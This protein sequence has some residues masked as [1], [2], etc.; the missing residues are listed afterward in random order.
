MRADRLIS[1]LLLLQA[2]RRMTAASLA[3][4]LEVSQRT[5]LRDMEALDR[6]GVPVV[7]ERG[8]GGGWR[9]IDGYETRLTGLTPVEIRSLFLGRPPELLAEL[10]LK[11]AAD[12]AWFKLRAALPAGI[13]EQADFVR[14]RILVDSRGWRDSVES[15]AGLPVILDALWRGRRLRFDYE[16]SSTDSTAREVDPLGL[17]A[18]GNH[19]Y[20]VAARNA[21]TRTYRVSR[22]RS[23][24]VLEAAS[25]RPPNFDLAAYWQTSTTRFREHLPRY[26]AAFLV[27]PAAMPWVRYRGWRLVE[28]T[29]EDERVR[30]RLRFDSAV[31]AQQFAL[32]LGADLEVL[33]PDE[34]KER[35][36]AAAQ[37]IIAAHARRG[38]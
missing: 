26:D 35:V 31:E 4:R 21:E 28:E 7:A 37:A 1:I 17:V 13:R 29:P 9:L 6:A 14:Q 19:W 8:A 16:K 5:I 27:V 25:A 22:M 2:N 36:L 10:G 11:D 3:T 20:L 15:L 24:E 38:G 33:E 30:V 23:A 18:R 12:A 34:L 32:S